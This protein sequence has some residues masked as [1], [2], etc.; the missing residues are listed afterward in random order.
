MEFYWAYADYQELISFIEKYYRFIVKETLGSEKS[1][2]GK[3]DIDWS[4]KWQQVDYFHAFKDETGIDLSKNPK[5][6]EL[7]IIAEKIGAKP[8][9][10]LGEGRLIDLIYKKTIRPKIIQP[11]LLL[12]HPVA[13]SPLA[14]R[15]D[16]NPQKVQ[17]VQV[18]AAGTEVGN[19][20]SELNN[21]QDQQER[22]KEQQELRKAGDQEA[23]MYDKDFIEALE[24]GMPPTS[25]IG[26]SIDRLIMILTN[27]RSIKDVILFPTLKPESHS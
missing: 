11:S 14:K 4:R 16:K 2:H 19:G 7:Y 27:S 15:D 3:K 6:E 8:G 21:P 18:L 23:Q 17:R 10:N 9:K 1:R 22:F 25:G 24:Y 12:N 20:W 13:V 26:P 5:K